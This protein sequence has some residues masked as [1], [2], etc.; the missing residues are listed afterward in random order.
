MTTPSRY[1][2]IDVTRAIAAFIVVVSH[3]QQLI[4]D[5][6]LTPGVVHRLLSILTTQGHNAV[7]VFFVISGFWIVR[8]VVRNGERFSYKEYLIAR[9]T[10]LWIVLLPALAIG[11][12]LDLMGSSFFPSPFYEG[13]QGSVA[14]TY[15]V[16][17]R[18]SATTLLGNILFLQDIAVPSYGSNGALW[19]LACEFWYYVYF[20]LAYLAVQSRRWWWIVCAGAGLLLL[21]GSHLFLC[22]LMGGL[23]YY[24]AEHRAATRSVHWIA[25][26]AALGV[27]AAVNLGSKLLELPTVANDLL[28]AASFSVFLGLGIRSTFG[29]ARGLSGLAALGSRSSYSLYAIHLPVL[30][31]VCNFIVADHRIA[32]SVWSWSL[33]VGLPIFVAAG[34]VL[35]SRLTEDQ[36]PRARRWISAAL[37]NPPGR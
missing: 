30:V 32:A 36:T 27:F 15:D 13:A 5:R 11:G 16:A 37:N 34:A 20:P 18:L 29:A 26:V 14:L 8:S 12:V 3:A 23:V 33:V 21:P 7:V 1:D 28:L 17:S 22:W 2:F 35:F 24:A 9:G 31:F 19:T 4:I 25:P 6:P 10:R